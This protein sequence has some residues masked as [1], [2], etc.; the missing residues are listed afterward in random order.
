[1]RGPHHTIHTLG[2]RTGLTPSNGDYAQYLYDD[3]YQLTS[4]HSKHSEWEKGSRWLFPLRH[5]RPRK[6]RK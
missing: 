1:M 6:D 4:K 3:T 5:G 2:N